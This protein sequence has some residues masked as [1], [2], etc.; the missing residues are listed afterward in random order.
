MKRKKIKTE[1]QAAVAEMERRLDDFIRSTADQAPAH[2]ASD[3]V[4]EIEAMLDGILSRSVVTPTDAS[5][6]EIMRNR[7]DKTL[8]VSDIEEQLNYILAD[9]KISPLEAELLPV[10]SKK[11]EETLAASAPE[12]NDIRVRFRP[13]ETGG[14]F[15]YAASDSILVPAAAG[16]PILATPQTGGEKPVAVRR[17]NPLVSMGNGLYFSEKDGKIYRKRVKR[18]F[19]GGKLRH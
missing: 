1:S 15:R 6:I 10:L 8:T 17:E 18:G 3:D 9:G 14:E 13:A 2:P 7:L 5:L 4:N 12:T 16:D 11:L 19:L